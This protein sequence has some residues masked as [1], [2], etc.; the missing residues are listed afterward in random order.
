MQGRF[1]TE[2]YPHLQG[3]INE[4]D[5]PHA[6][7]QSWTQHRVNNEENTTRQQNLIENF[8]QHIINQQQE[9]K[10]KYHDLLI[11]QKIRFPSI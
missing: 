7:D 11:A 4:K 8:E 10:R 2:G 1:I 3:G 9:P 6:Q 5:Y